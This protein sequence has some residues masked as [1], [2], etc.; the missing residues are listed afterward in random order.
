MHAVIADGNQ[1]YAI[2]DPDILWIKQLTKAKMH[3]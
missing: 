1:A 2:L 3:Y